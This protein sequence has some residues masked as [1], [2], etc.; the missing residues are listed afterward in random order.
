M[1]TLFHS[2]FVRRAS[3]PLLPRSPVR[4]GRKMKTLNAHRPSGLPPDLGL[5][6]GVAFSYNAQANESASFSKIGG[7]AACFSSI[8]RR[9]REECIGMG[10]ACRR[11]IGAEFHH[12]EGIP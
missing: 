11:V 12:Q 5:A 8:L 3:K 10:V 7:S 6:A 1:N 9:R 2:H 4:L